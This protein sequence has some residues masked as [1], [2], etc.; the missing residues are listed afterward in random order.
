MNRKS[1]FVI[2]AIIIVTCLFAGC[3]NDSSGG[4]DT[5]VKVH[6]PYGNGTYTGDLTGVG[7]GYG[8][9]IGGYKDVTVTLHLVNGVINSVAVSHN[10]T[11]AVGGV[12]INKV[13]PL[14]IEAN[15]FEVDALTK[16]TAIY[17]REA[18]LEAGEEALSK[19]PY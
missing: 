18:L 1:L 8:D 19:I 4:D 10:E 9:G 7:E 3:P 13:R 16:A 5:K 15:S 14:I 2:A 17:T 11:A 6:K 12:L